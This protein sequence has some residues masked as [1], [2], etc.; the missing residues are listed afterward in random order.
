MTPEQAAL[1]EELD[2]H[3]TSHSRRTLLEHLKG[4]HDLLAQWGNPAW[5]CTAG[6]FHSIYGTYIFDRKS[7]DLS[8]RA[9]IREVIGA[10]AEELVFVFCVCDR[11]RFY[12][13]L[14]ESRIRVRDAVHA[15][16]LE[17]DRQSLA[18]LI[19]IEVANVVEQVPRRSRKKALQAAELY[20]PAFRRSRDYISPMA[21]EAAERCFAAVLADAQRLNE[22]RCRS[23]LARE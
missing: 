6:L 4:T 16:D 2:A 12:D 8:M 17:L 5:L 21:A 13:H 7:A 14:G 22:A 18:A 20:A 23:E 15:R 1:L 9:R 19:E 10:R 3:V 11:R